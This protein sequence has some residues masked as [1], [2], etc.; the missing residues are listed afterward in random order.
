MA[1]DISFNSLIGRLADLRNLPTYLDDADQKVMGAVRDRVRTVTEGKEPGRMDRNRNQKLQ[2]NWHALFSVTANAAL[3]DDIIF[4]IKDT[5]AA[6][7]RVFEYYV[8]VVEKTTLTSAYVEAVQHKL[9]YNFGQMGM[10]YSAILGHQSERVKK[11]VDEANEEWE[12]KLQTRA[13]ERF[14]RSFCACVMVGAKLANECGAAFNL[15]L[16]A[17]FLYDRF[18]ELRDKMMTS[19]SM[20]GGGEDF[21]VDTLTDF[22]KTMEAHSI[23]S[24]AI[25]GGSGRKPAVATYKTPAFDTDIHVHWIPDSR[26]VRI[27]RDKFAEYLDGKERTAG[28]VIKGLRDHFKM[29]IARGTIGAGTTRAQGPE[30][31]MM[32]DVPPGSIWEEL[33]FKWVPDD[34]RPNDY[35][36]GPPGSVAAADLA[37]V[38]QM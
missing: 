21:V 28:V 15:D 33:L 13:V 37:L 35:D 25:P 32:M 7:V 9:Q 8:P 18:M 23:W 24:H 3:G 20:A 10:R 34:K 4:K 17:P 12:A 14:W 16:M 27:S 19:T 26:A 31:L 1:S 11:L 36:P 29:T 22:L 38:R 5:S 30:T 6:F 2:R